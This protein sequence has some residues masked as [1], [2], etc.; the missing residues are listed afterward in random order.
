[1]NNTSYGGRYILQKEK[2]FSTKELR[3][4]KIMRKIKK[5]KKRKHD[6][7]HDLLPTYLLN[8]SGGEK[9]KKTRATGP[10]LLNGGIG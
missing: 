3:Q 5:K 1:M 10:T 2:L 6:K 7:R 9:G 8:E 4:I